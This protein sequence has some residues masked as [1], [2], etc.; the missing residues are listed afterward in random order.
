MPTRTIKLPTIRVVDDD[1]PRALRRPA[2]HYVCRA[3]GLSQRDIA[4][5]AGTVQGVVAA[6]MTGRNRARGSSVRPATVK[7]L[8]ERGYRYT[9]AELFDR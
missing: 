2:A 3:V 8:A 6:V 9:E 7:L 1:H 5:E 4:G